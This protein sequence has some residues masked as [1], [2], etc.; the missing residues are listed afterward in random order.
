M[1]SRREIVQV[2]VLI[3]LLSALA[4]VGKEGLPQDKKHTEDY[5]RCTVCKEA[6]TKALDFL[7]K[8]QKEDGSFKAS[9][10]VAEG[11]STVMTTALAGLAFL[12]SGSSLS[13][14]HYKEPLGKIYNYLSKC[15][16]KFSAKQ[17]RWVRI[18]EY[19]TKCL[20]LLF[21]AHIYER[22]KNDK[23]AELL[24]G[25]VK[26]LSERQGTGVTKSHWGGGKDDGTIWYISG[27]TAFL[28]LYVAAMTRA[29]SVGID[30]EDKVF[31]LPRKYYPEMLEKNGSFKY[32][33]HNSFPKEPRQAR[34]I[35]ALLTLMNLGI[36]GDEKFKPAFEY[37]RGKIH[38][39]M[40]HHIPQFHMML[41][42]YTFYY[43]GK[44]D[45]KKYVA[46]YFDKLISRQQADGRI[47]KLWDMDSKLMEKPNDLEFGKNYATAIFALILQVPREQVKLKK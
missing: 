38:E 18:S 21:I 23:T 40:T 22:D 8:E 1:I 31:E 12:A 42:A 32:D 3:V 27:V 45:W 14:G 34:S 7:A 13:S 9:D 29:K 4:P 33:Q 46:M 41:C 26:D 43:L 15:T 35:V 17:P 37:A 6:V 39:T 28:N 47:D 11:A 36:D 30:V 2:F 25:L 20:Y 19:Y 24:N 5:A 10:I 44:E 16:F